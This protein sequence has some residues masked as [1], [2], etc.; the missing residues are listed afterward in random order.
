MGDFLES[1]LAQNGIFIGGGVGGALVAVGA[2]VY[3][4]K[5]RE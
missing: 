4:K 5:Y 3:L 1:F 2:I